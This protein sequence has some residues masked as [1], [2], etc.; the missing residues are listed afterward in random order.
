MQSFANDQRPRSSRA[1]DRAPGLAEGP[2][3]CVNVA[4]RIEGANKQLD[5]RV[6]FSDDCYQRVAEFVEIG[7]TAGVA[8][9]GKTG[10]FNL[11]EL[12]GMRG[13]GR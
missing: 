10:T 4:S 8:L 3:A 11:Y 12:T 5:T 1:H 7:R 13:G 6:L 2:A 9:K